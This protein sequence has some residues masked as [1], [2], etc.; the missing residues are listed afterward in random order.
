M[1]SSVFERGAAGERKASFS[2]GVGQKVSLE[3][4]E[5][6]SDIF[7]L[8]V[9]IG[10]NLPH[11]HNRDMVE[12]VCGHTFVQITTLQLLVVEIGLEMFSG[13]ELYS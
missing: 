5:A 8:Y 7:I 11:A 13:M 3:R 6:Q 1:W 12:I 9:R 4:E 2:Q 10:G